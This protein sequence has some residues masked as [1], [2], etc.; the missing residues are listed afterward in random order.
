MNGKGI[1]TVA[2][3][4]TFIAFEATFAGMSVLADSLRR[5]LTKSRVPAWLKADQKLEAAGST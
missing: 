4:P 3:I 1:R 2:R 5:T